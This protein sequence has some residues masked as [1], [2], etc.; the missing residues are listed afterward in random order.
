[1]PLDE[2]PCAERDEI[3]AT[4]MM[5]ARA[6]A[7]VS[8]ERTLEGVYRVLCN[9]GADFPGLVSGWVGLVEPGTPAV[10]PVATWGVKMEDL[11]DVRVTTD[12]S[13]TGRGPVGRALR[14]G[15][16]AVMDSIDHP[17]FAPWRDRI[18]ALGVRSVAA[19]PLKRPDGEQV[20][21]LVIYGDRDGYF[22]PVR[23]ALMMI[24][25]E[26]ASVAIEN[27][28]L[29]ERLARLASDK[30]A[31]AQ[32]R[33]EEL[34]RQNVELAMANERLAESSRYKTEFLSHMSHELRSPLTAILGFT[35]VL[36]DE[37]VGP[38]NDKQKEHLG[39]VGQAGRQ[40]LDVIDNVVELS[41]VESGRSVLEVADCYPHQVLEAAASQLGTVTTTSRGVVTWSVSTS[42]DLK[43]RADARKLRQVLANL[44]AHA[45]RTAGSGGRVALGADVADGFL[46]LSVG[47]TRGATAPQTT[48]S[49]A[50][51]RSSTFGVALAHR[52]V[53][54]HGGRVDRQ[55]RPDGGAFVVFLPLAT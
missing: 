48:E 27:A 13:P 8:R 20:G 10:V 29:S 53:E 26:V 51:I 18:A 14:T 11:R 38:L 4:A 22:T 7:R 33:T 25:A 49:T 47:W 39:H 41:R 30:E 42:A 9:A 16:V 37:L 52:L 15:R 44:A 55:E 32:R 40:L 12:D 23:Q 45:L 19:V 54:L 2:D 43:F 24:F 17:D 1:M 46:R 50:R 31:S 36:R 35:E 6:A 34:G 5:L 28:R 21:A 3:I